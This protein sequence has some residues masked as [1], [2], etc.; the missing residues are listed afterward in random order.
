MEWTMI[1]DAR[2]KAYAYDGDGND[3]SISFDGYTDCEAPLG[4]DGVV[5]T[6][7]DER[8]ASVDVE[9][10]GDDA[11]AAGFDMDAVVSLVVE[12]LKTIAEAMASGTSADDAEQR[13][14]AGHADGGVELS[15]SENAAS[16]RTHFKGSTA[17][18]YAFYGIADPQPSEVGIPTPERPDG[19]RVVKLNVCAPDGACA[20]D[21]CR[22]LFM[23]AEDDADRE[24]VTEILAALDAALCRAGE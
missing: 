4:G 12:S 5:L 3:W 18:G 9:Y 20:Y 13:E 8:V 2:L 21:Y 6:R 16:G 19:S 7:N 15:I 23:P 11:E 10:F 14:S 17:D 22:A 24:A 1:T